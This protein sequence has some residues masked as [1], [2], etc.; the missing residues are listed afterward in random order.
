[1]L[2]IWDRVQIFWSDIKFENWFYRLK[3]LI[4]PDYQCVGLY[5]NY[6]V[7]LKMGI[8]DSNVSSYSIIN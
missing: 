7:V 6:D 4:Q 5:Q 8:T 2:A 3:I 1:M